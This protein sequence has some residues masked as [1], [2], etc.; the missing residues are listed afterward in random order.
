MPSA[1]PFH[2][3]V[4][5]LLFLSVTSLTRGANAAPDPAACRA[6]EDR[7]ETAAKAHDW[8][9][10]LKDGE[11]LLRDC[12]ALNDTLKGA[13]YTAIAE[14]QLR[15]G[16]LDEALTAARACGALGSGGPFY[17]D[18][19]FLEADALDGLRAL[20]AWL[21]AMREVDALPQ[22]EAGGEAKA[23]AGPAETRQRP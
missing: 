5:S 11:Q 9:R 10:L 13:A 21:Q 23:D 19:R 6:L 17:F 8:P 12:G 15:T 20:Q 4:L 3:S 7:T 16:K 18:C 22:P 1:S 14:A 2:L